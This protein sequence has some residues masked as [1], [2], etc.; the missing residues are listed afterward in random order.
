MHPTIGGPEA[1]AYEMERMAPAGE[2]TRLLAIILAGAT[3]HGTVFCPKCG[4]GARV[5]PNEWHVC[6]CGT[7]HL[8]TL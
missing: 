3:L 4:Q 6:E 8:V 5:A 1:Q 7:Q 2:S